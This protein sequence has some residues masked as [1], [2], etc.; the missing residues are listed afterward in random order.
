MGMDRDNGSRADRRGDPSDIFP[1]HFLKSN[2][3]V[4]WKF[5]ARC[6]QGDILDLHRL[7]LYSSASCECGSCAGRIAIR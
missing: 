2:D 1:T 5:E 4:G 6:V 7:S 3:V